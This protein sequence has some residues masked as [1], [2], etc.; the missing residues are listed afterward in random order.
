MILMLFSQK[1]EFLR[2]VIVIDRIKEE[3]QFII[4]KYMY[5]NCVITRKVLMIFR[6]PKRNPFLIEIRC[7]GIFSP[8]HVRCVD[9]NTVQN[10]R[11]S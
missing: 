9:K 6:I 2:C 7:H 4:T 5:V 11:E 3:F 10:S 1:Y 8:P